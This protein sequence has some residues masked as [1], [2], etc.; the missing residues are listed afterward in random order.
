VLRAVGVDDHGRGRGPDAEFLE[1]LRALGFV[2]IGAEQ[3]EMLVQETLKLGILVKLLTQQSTARSATRVKIEEDLLVFRPGL[4]HGFVQ[5]AL[6][7]VL[8]GRGRRHEQN[9]RRY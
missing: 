6:V 9:H 2:A 8:G 3:D 1:D 5:G 4:G 7:P